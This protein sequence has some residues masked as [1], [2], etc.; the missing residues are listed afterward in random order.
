MNNQELFLKEI[1]KQVVTSASLNDEIAIVLNCFDISPKTFER[2]KIV[3]SFF[4]AYWYSI[5]SL[6]TAGVYT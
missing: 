5:C 4:S 6:A 1:R 3:Y 2:F